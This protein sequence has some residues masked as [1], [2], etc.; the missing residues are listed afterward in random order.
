MD[1]RGTQ[2][3]QGIYDLITI[4]FKKTEEAIEKSEYFLKNE[5]DLSEL[6]DN[7]F[8]HIS[9]ASSRLNNALIL[10]WVNKAALEKF[11]K[12]SELYEITT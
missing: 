12:I 1:Q 2:Q 11:L 5:V 8:S 4:S 9:S 3:F 6:F 7:P 10:L